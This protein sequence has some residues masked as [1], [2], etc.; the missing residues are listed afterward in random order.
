MASITGTITGTLST[1]VKWEYTGDLVDGFTKQGTGTQTYSNGLEYSGA[2]ADGKRHGHGVCK[3]ENGDFYEGAF[4][5]GEMHGFGTFKYGSGSVFTGN[6]SGGKIHGQ[7]K[8]VIEIANEDGS[9][10]KQVTQEGEFVEGVFVPPVT[11]DPK[12]AKKKK[13]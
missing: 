11:E 8:L 5:N 7:G 3:W 13:K 6:F 2:F 4:M 12:K 1:G 9:D 10:P